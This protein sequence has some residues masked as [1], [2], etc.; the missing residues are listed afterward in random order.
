MLIGRLA[1]RLA[2]I[3]VL[4]LIGCFLVFVMGY[5]GPGDPVQTILGN[6]WATPA[7]YERL[8]QNLGLDRPLLVQFSTYVLNA[9]QG[10]FGTSW[11]RGL[12]VAGLLASGLS[13]TVQLVAAA[14]VV[15]V[16]IGIPAGVIAALRHNR[17]TDRT[18]VVTGIT[19]HAIP[20]Y[21]L[22]PMLMVLFVLQLRLLP[23]PLGWQ[24]LFTPGAIIPILTLA[25]GPLIFVIRQTRGA[26][27][28]TM[29][30]DYMRTA[31]AMGLRRTTVLSRYLLPNSMSPVV[32][33]LGLIFGGLL[34][35]SIFVEAI[36][37]I[38]GFGAMIFNSVTLEDY[39]LL[40]GATI[41][42]IIVIGLAYFA[43]DILLAL[44]DRRIRIS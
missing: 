43:T 31:K 40:V 16:I 15:A 14:V 4:A 27:L 41:V 1:I 24:G 5:Y 29:G 13:I 18:I 17:F 35:N 10:D 2:S 21:V 11:Q 39:P 6:T 3:A 26:I 20:P 36:F 34:V 37:N 32:N 30:E 42:A 8:R 28:N 9:L 25:A 19:F 7:E 44:V 33:E 38:P 12:P 22:A 23:V